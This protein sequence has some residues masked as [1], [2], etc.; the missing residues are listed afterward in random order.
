MTGRTTGSPGRP[1]VRHFVATTAD[2]PLG[3]FAVADSILD[4]SG[5]LAL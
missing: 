4:S 5:G 2:N 1:P 3:G